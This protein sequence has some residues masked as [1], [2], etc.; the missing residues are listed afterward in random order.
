[1]ELLREAEQVLSCKISSCRICSE[2]DFEDIFDF[3]DHVLSGRFPTPNESDAP[4]APLRMIL[5]NAC[6]FLQLAHDFEL[7]ELYR[8]DY[9]Y[10]S[11]INESMC[12]HLADL[13]LQITSCIDLVAGD[14][15]LDIGSNDG[16]LL[17][18]YNTG[19]DIRLVGIDPTVEQFSEY[20][21]PEILTVADFFS[22][23][24]F[25][26]ISGGK[27]ARVITSVAMFYDLPAPNIFVAD[28]AQALAPDGIWVLELCYL[29]RMLELNAFD[30]ICHEHL[31]YYALAQIEF[32][33]G[34]HGLRVFD[35]AFNDV[36]G[37]SFLISACHQDAA[38]FEGPS[39]EETRVREAALG[40]DTSVPFN[41]FWQRIMVARDQIRSF[42]DEQ[43]KLG[44]TVLGYGASTKGNTTL[45]FCDISKDQIRATADRN[46]KKWGR[47]LPRTGIPIIS[48][49]EA[50]LMRPDYFIAFPWH[51]RD[52]FLQREKAFLDAGGHFV[53]LLPTF[54]IV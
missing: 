22:A 47:R 7:N 53:F 10:R 18:S 42:L 23:D 12:V 4:T 30:T 14:L 25:N 54:E 46:Q 50:R 52:S 5:C 34:S 27:Q 26:N 33:L 28:L 35:V 49:D 24:A 37:G 17:K 2:R 16:T 39:V 44:K 9:G 8:H 41:A 15:V 38:Y 51:F 40:L 1:M 6:G 43:A 3:G 29:P 45:Q 13:T 32:L 11:G 48:E 31:G 21:P 19:L 36:N 20:Y